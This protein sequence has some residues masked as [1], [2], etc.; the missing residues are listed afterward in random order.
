MERTIQGDRRSGVALMM[1]LVAMLVV[2]GG[3]FATSGC[4]MLYPCGAEDREY[5]VGD[6]CVCGDRCHEND[7]SECSSHEVC[8]RYEFDPSRGVCVDE[9]F[10]QRHADEVR[11][12]GA[13]GGGG[14]GDGGSGNGLDGL[15]EEDEGDEGDNEDDTEENQ[16]DM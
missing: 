1:A 9:E 14:G 12:L 10:R 2:V 13:E 11:V 7:Q 4:T 6:D 15:G 3:I 8:A 5:C 16:E